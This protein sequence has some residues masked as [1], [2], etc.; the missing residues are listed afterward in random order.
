MPADFDPA[1]GPKRQ[2]I[3]ERL[4]AFMQK[5]AREAKRFTSWTAPAKAYEDALQGFVAAAMSR[6][7]SGDFLEAFWD[8]AQP[9]VA[10]GALNSLSQTLIKLTA[11]G[12]PDIYQGTE[13]YD[14]S[15]VDPDNRR[16][17]DFAARVDA[18]ADGAGIA[19]A[20]VRWRDGRVKAKL[21]A[22]VLKVRSAAPELFT[23]GDYLPLEVEGPQAEH[24]L[25]F[26]RVDNLGR[27]AV[28]VAPRM[29]AKLLDGRTDLLV[30][31]SFWQDTTIQLPSRLGTAAFTDTLGNATLPAGPT[32]A[33]DQLLRDF[34][35][36]LFSFGTHERSSS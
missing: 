25:A 31:A 1:D 14:F 9:L 30:P 23:Q 6:E 4:N 32:L 34:P 26:A 17:I 35:F 20:L 36:A 5:A 19:E 7:Q 3:G 21:T 27:A 24:A 12:V 28:V 2:E 16:P 13:F 10:A 29:T 22:A 8:R 33:L 18:M 15:L 11:P